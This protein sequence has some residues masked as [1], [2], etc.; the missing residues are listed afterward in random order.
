MSIRDDSVPRRV[1]VL[2][3]LQNL[4]YGGMERLLFEM[5]R[6]FDRDRFDNHVLALQF[7][8]RFGQGL[9][10]FAAVS[11]ARPMTRASLLRPMSLARDIRSVAPDVVHTHSGVWYKASLA[12]RLAGVPWLVHTEHGRAAPDPLS[13]RLLDGMASRRTDIVVAVSES[14]GRALRTSVSRRP[15]RVHVVPNGVDADVFR[16]VADDR[17]IRSELALSS[18]VPIIGSVGRLEP[19]KGYEVMVDAYA[20]LRRRWLGDE[21]PVLV[22]AGDGSERARLAIRARELHVDDGIRW[23]G[24]RDDMHRLHA[25]FTLFTMSSHSEGTSVSLLEAM[26][27]GLCPVVTR[28]GG[29]G[30][31][32][33]PALQHRLVPPNDPEQLAT[34]WIGALLDP[35]P[36][37]V[38]ALAARARVL[39]AFT[40]DAMVA[41]YAGLYMRGMPAST[42]AMCAP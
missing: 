39:E 26:S 41:S 3:I 34:A 32:L 42:T 15:E 20:V 28:V 19:V 10:Q 1:R 33:G 37:R 23:L 5:L 16:P 11:V 7:V 8:G 12:A 35:T 13:A 27:A 9:E 18:T 24:W 25:A 30:A 22:I 2:H 40:L 4:N 21:P 17:G 31:V 29:N 36:R 38:D 6:R 14:V